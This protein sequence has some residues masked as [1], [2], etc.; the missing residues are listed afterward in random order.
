MNSRY[1]VVGGREPIIQNERGFAAKA[2]HDEAEECKGLGDPNRRSSK[3]YL[4]G[5]TKLRLAVD[6]VPAL[7]G[8]EQ[9]TAA[10]ACG[11]GWGGLS[12]KTDRRGY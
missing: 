5:D 2:D 6:F 3:R 1:G 4:P 7:M 10:M 9:H 8:Y 12:L 11:V